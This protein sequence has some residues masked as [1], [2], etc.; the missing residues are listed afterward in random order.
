MHDEGLPQAE[1]ADLLGVSQ[2]TV[3]LDL[4]RLRKRRR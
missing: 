1:I 4:K 2:A 3:S